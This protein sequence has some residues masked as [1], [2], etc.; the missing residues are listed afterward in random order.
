[1]GEPQ[2]SAQDLSLFVAVLCSGLVGFALFELRG[3]LRP[4]KVKVLGLFVFAIMTVPCLRGWFAYQSSI[5]PADANAIAEMNSLNGSY[6]VS[7]QIQPTIY[8]LFIN[9]TYVPSGGDY[10]IYR[11]VP[12][13]GGTTPNVRWTLVSGNGSV[14]SDYSGLPIVARFN[15]GKV[16]VIIYKGD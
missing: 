13:T 7:S 1:M 9:K 14:E 16:S 6:S 12:M 11:N 5:H 4:T 15:D 2:R 8:E 3:M 10:I